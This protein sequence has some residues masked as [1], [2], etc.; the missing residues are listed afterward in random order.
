MKNPVAP[1][2]AVGVSVTYLFKYELGKK[3]KHVWREYLMLAFPFKS[4]EQ[5]LA[6][7]DLKYLDD[8][9]AQKLSS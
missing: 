4:F 1:I 3:A 7:Y 6:N 9:I 8:E 5:K 2:L